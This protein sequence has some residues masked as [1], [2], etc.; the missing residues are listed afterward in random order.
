MSKTLQNV[1]YL[2]GHD[3]DDNGNILSHVN[4]NKPIIL[5]LQGNFCG[6][7]TQAK[8]AF[9]QLSQQVPSVLVATVQIDGSQKDKEASAKLSKVNKNPGVP[10]YLG[11]DKNGRFV[12]SHTG[13][14]DMESLKKF[15]QSL[16]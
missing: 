12:K 16:F 5:M 2:E 13:G 10:A 1:I 14:R 4:S 8:P 6:Y 15:A 3:I 11:F 7:C 9:Q